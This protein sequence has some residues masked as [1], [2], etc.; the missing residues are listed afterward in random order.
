M[1]KQIETIECKA[2]VSV[3]E[4]NIKKGNIYIIKRDHPL[5]S[6]FQDTKIFEHVTDPAK[7]LRIGDFVVMEGRFEY[8]GR[9]KRVN[10]SLG[11][12]VSIVP[13]DGRYIITIHNYD[14]RNYTYNTKSIGRDHTDNKCLRT[15]IRVYWF[16]NSSGS[17]CHTFEGKDRAADDFRRRAGNMFDSHDEAYHRYEQ[18]IGRDC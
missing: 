4:F 17:I 7:T 14:G 16:L 1:N 9:P 5:W 13:G 3:P 10:K 6:M 8:N 11:I 12:I 2:L 15:D 18:I